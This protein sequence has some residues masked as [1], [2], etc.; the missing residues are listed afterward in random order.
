MC[1]K[2]ILKC[3]GCS[4]FEENWHCNENFSYLCDKLHDLIVSHHIKE[5]LG[6]HP[7]Q[8]LG[9]QVTN[10]ARLQ[11]E[12]F[13]VSKPSKTVGKSTFTTQGSLCE[14]Y[15]TSQVWIRDLERGPLILTYLPT[16]CSSSLIFLL[17]RCPSSSSALSGFSVGCVRVS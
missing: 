17:W 9:Y 7:P 8:P 16:S 5:G 15:F 3:R 2:F 6:V 13:M 1:Q 4:S 11:R 14:Q 12:I 10:T